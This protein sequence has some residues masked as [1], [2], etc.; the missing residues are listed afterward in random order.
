M[1]QALVQGATSVVGM[2]ANLQTVPAIIVALV[3]VAFAFF[4]YTIFRIAL[5]V[6]GAGVGIIVSNFV[7]QLF[8]AQGVAR[9]IITIVVTIIMIAL[10][11]SIQKLA[12]FVAGLGVGYIIGS[13]INAMVAAQNPQFAEGF[14][15]FIIPIGVGIL[16]GILHLILFKYLFI[17]ETS[18]GGMVLAL[19]ILMVGVFHLN[20]MLS[21]IPLVVGLVAGVFAMVCQFR[22]V[23]KKG[24]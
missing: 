9:I 5:A 23:A 22:L 13:S 21:W 1:N 17:I 6:L 11:I 3:C 24:D 4:G 19:Y 7:C 14:M 12:L 10:V 20:P 15:R 16:L 8:S 18:I 2:L